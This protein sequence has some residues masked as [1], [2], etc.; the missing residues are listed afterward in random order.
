[1]PALPRFIQRTILFPATMAALLTVTA[2]TVPFAA[3]AY[4][5]QATIAVNIDKQGVALKGYDPVSYFSAAGPVQGQATFSQTHAGATYWFASAANRYAFKAD[6]GKYAPEFGGFCAMGAALNKK[7]DVDP[8]LWR[9]VDGKLYLNVH[10][11]AQTRWLEDV[12]GN[13]AKA[14][15]NWPQ[16][17]D[18]A[19]SAL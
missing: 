6:P 14:Y 17:K 4:D 5:E 15:R 13:L 2:A 19:P 18:K 7:L 16:I 12:A 8:Q 11:E 9:I 3:H 1:M 10:K